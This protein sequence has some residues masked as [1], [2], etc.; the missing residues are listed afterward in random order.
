MSVNNSCNSSQNN[1]F[2]ATD[3]RIKRF[4]CKGLRVN[5][6]VESLALNIVSPELRQVFKPPLIPHRKDSVKKI[7]KPLK[8][9]FKPLLLGN[10]SPIEE[11]K[12]TES[13]SPQSPAKWVCNNKI[14]LD[15]KRYR[16]IYKALSKASDGDRNMLREFFYGKVKLQFKGKLGSGSTSDVHRAQTPDGRDVVV[17]ILNS[18]PGS[19]EVRG[20]YGAALGL[21]LPKHSRIGRAHSV[22]VRS[23]DDTVEIRTSFNSIKNG[24]RHIAVI[25][26]YDP[27]SVSLTTYISARQIPLSD[28]AK[29]GL[30]IIEGMQECHKEGILHSDYTLDNIRINERRKSISIS[31]LGHSVLLGS[32]RAERARG[33]AIGF[34]A[35]EIFDG[36][37][38]KK[39]D[40][41]TFGVILYRLTMGKLPFN[42]FWHIKEADGK[43]LKF[44]IKIPISLENL[45]RALLNPVPNERASFE[46]ASKILSE[47]TK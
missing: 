18:R 28:V 8:G 9:M 38:S 27:G 34:Q 1:G 17:K 12:K 3:T 31:D 43:S 13:N 24:D 40:L 16:G 26:P 2:Q 37:A 7:F 47:L 25:S 39:S 4:E 14:Q 36:K 21:K 5:P 15:P 29:F 42:D 41:W 45:I 44:P 46:R 35:P 19:A 10:S 30:Q 32:Q 6:K 22:I 23:A 11:G 33:G 20:P